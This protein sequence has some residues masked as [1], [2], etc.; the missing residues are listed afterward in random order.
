M[1][2]WSSTWKEGDSL[3]LEVEEL[4]S[5]LGPEDSKEDFRRI[6]E[7]VRNKKGRTIFESFSSEGP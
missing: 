6:L 4:E 5:L 7:E 3:Q 2:E 1:Q